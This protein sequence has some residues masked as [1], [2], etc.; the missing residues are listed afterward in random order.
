M[1]FNVPSSFSGIY[2]KQGHPLYCQMSWC[3]FKT[4]CFYKNADFYA[5]LFKLFISLINQC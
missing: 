2:R 1:L 4:K 3:D 5:D